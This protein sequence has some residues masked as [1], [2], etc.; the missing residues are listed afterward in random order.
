MFAEGACVFIAE[1]V[2]LVAFRD[3]NWEHAFF[4]LLAGVPE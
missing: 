2:A 3:G 4:I 1:V